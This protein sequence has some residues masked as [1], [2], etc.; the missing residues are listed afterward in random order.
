MIFSH[1]LVLVLVKELTAGPMWEE[2]MKQ[3]IRTGHLIQQA[4]LAALQ[5]PKQRSKAR[6]MMEAT[7]VRTR[8]LW[9]KEKMD[10]TVGNLRR[11]LL[12]N[13]WKKFNR[14][15]QGALYG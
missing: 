2:Y 6:F 4:K 3:L 14:S 5:P 13:S 8:V 12:K 9:V 15:H 7:L 11:Q 10:E 1:K